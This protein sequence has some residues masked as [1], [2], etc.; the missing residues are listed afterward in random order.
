MIFPRRMDRGS[1]SSDDSA[2][3]AEL[4]AYALAVAPAV[5]V[6]FVDRVMAAVPAH[7]PVAHGAPVRRLAGIPAMAAAWLGAAVGRAAGREGVPIRLRIQAAG[8]VIVALLAVSA[9]AA[10]AVAGTTSVI[11]WVAP[12]HP[13]PASTSGPLQASPAPA[14][15]PLP[16]HSTQAPEPTEPTE[17]TERPHPSATPNPDKSDGPDRTPRPSDDHGGSGGGSGSG[18]S[19]GSQDT[20]EPTDPGGTGSDSGQ[21]G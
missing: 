8:L 12:R 18:G 6:D 14:L 7:V 20:P 9:G 21:G 5:P 4:E 2:V 3:A 17:P 1:M 13:V 15:D 16:G 10:L 19:H 11:D